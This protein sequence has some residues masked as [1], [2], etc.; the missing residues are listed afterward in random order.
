M[1]C[2]ALSSLLSQF[3]ITSTN[4]NIQHSKILDS[5]NMFLSL[6]FSFHFRLLFIIYVSLH[7]HLYLCVYFSLPWIY[8]V[9]YYVKVNSK[10]SL[11]L[12]YSSS[13][14]CALSLY[15]GSALCLLTS[16]FVYLLQILNTIANVNNYERCLKMCLCIC[17]RTWR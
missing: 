17:K 14:I 1:I 3:K 7:V 13:L 11:N 6:N 4:T 5:F 15:L 12:P 2:H 16:L 8:W 9:F 10:F